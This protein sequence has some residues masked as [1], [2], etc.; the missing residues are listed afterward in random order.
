MECINVK[1]R[2]VAIVMASSLMLGNMMTTC[3]AEIPDANEV[4]SEAVSAG[5]EKESLPYEVMVD[6]EDGCEIAIGDGDWK[7]EDEIDTA[8]TPDGNITL[9]DD[10]GSSA[11]EGQQFITLVT[12]SGNY[13]YLIIDRNEKGEE[14]VYFLNMVD[15]ADLFA[16]MDEEDLAAYEETKAEEIEESAVIVEPSIKEESV[17]DE[18]N[19]EMEVLQGKSK[20]NV[21]PFGVIGIVFL[22]IGCAFLFKMKKKKSDVVKP[23]PDADYRDE[24]EDFCCIPDDVE[25]DTEGS[26]EL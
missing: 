22:G 5:T 14:N 4:V 9:V 13:F 21:L 8:L 16:L 7:F 23:D 19:K 11:E 17:V 10:I 25:E 15:E 6:D 24:T 26:G 20:M 2:I 3:Y 12:K 18:D 1:K